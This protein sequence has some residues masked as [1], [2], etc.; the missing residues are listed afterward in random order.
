MTGTSKRTFSGACGRSRTAARVR[1]RAILAALRSI[2]AQRLARRLPLRPLFLVTSAF[3]FIM[4]LRLIGGAVQELQEQLYIP[5]DV[6]ALP[7]WLIWLG[8]NPTRFGT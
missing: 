6:I 2:V 4:G 1:P 8:I 3:L 5:Y 7:E